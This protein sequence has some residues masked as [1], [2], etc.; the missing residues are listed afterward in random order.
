ME[1]R[2]V[3]GYEGYL[4]VSDTGL[5]RSVERE[6]RHRNNSTMRIK[7]RE[8][9]SHPDPKGYL[10]VRTSID[11]EKTSI[12]VH[13]AVAEAFIPNPDNKSQVD[14][15]DGNKTN[16]SVSNLRWTT[17]RENFDYSVTNGLRENSY[18]ALEDARD[19]EVRLAHLAESIRRRCSKKTY[20]YDKNMNLL[21]EYNSNEEAA[22]AVDGCQSGVSGCCCGKWKTYKGYI[23]SYIPPGNEEQNT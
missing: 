2:D 20:C 1:W 22:K 19:S 9:K 11:K 13:R 3:V 16:N 4:E 17:N 14:H 8:I 10:K 6:V 15:I 5:I 23:F 18:K 7:S 12:K 21:A